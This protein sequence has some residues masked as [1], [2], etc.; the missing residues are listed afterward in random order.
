MKI[1]KSSKTM[2]YETSN[3]IGL[4][5]NSQKPGLTGAGQHDH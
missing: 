3:N 4:A 5:I 1:N 2:Q